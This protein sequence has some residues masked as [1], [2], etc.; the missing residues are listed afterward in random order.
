MGPPR[1]RPDSPAPMGG[2]AIIYVI[3]RPIGAGLSIH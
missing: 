1:G 3:A 2:G